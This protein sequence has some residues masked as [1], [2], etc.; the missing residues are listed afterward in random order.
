MS[1]TAKAK[2]GLS[3]LID[4]RVGR[5]RGQTKQILARMFVFLHVARGRS[6]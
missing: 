1:G 5:H 6:Q 2:G 3:V 4:A